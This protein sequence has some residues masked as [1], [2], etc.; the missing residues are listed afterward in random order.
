[1]RKNLAGK[2]NI[3][4]RLLM[5]TLILLTAAMVLFPQR[6]YAASMAGLELWWKVVV[7][8]L[9]P[10]FFIS[11]L[12][13]E[14]GI[15]RWLTHAMSPLMR[16]VF[17]LPGCAALPVALGFCS[18]FPSG[19]AITASLRRR[20]MIT[21]EEGGRLL[22][23]TNNAGPLYISV[24]VAEGMLHCPRAAMILAA[25]QYGGNLLIGII[26]GILS[27]RRGH[28]L[29][30]AALSPPL[31][32]VRQKDGGQILKAAAARAAANITA[33]GCLMLFFSV[34]SSFLAAAAFKSPPLL[35]GIMQGFWEMSL[36]INSLAASELP[37]DILIPATAAILGFG[38]ISVHMQV[39]A[40]SGDTDIRFL[41]FFLCRL[42]HA[43][44]A[45]AAAACLCRGTVLPVSG[46]FILRPQPAGILLFSVTALLAALGVIFGLSLLAILLQQFFHHPDHKN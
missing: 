18:G 7:P 27:R 9:L 32:D 36:G 6:T 10:F 38:G 21:R 1:M 25:A 42:F 15:S 20:G 16:L 2:A 4:R 8:S 41:P 33:I 45:F 44:L 40:M 39:L 29:A 3:S 43:A 13:M 17:A 37:L 23:F 31:P 19:A 14:L 12:L 11:E 5:G 46:G 26:L 30:A 34:L 35:P 22:C 24:A 28:E